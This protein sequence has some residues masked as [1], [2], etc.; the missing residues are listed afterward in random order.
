MKKPARGGLD[1]DAALGRASS[2]YSPPA[3]S[4]VN[5]LPVSTRR[6]YLRACAAWRRIYDHHRAI[7]P[8]LAEGWCPACAGEGCR[9]CDDSGRCIQHELRHDQGAREDAQVSGA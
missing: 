3:D 9:H 2:D 8:L 1:R 4:A 7:V 5:L 6:R